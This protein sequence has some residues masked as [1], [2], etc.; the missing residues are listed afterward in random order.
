[1][2][3]GSDNYGWE[4]KGSIGASG[5]LLCIWNSM[6]FVKQ[7]VLLGDGFLCISGEWGPKRLKCNFVN[8]YASN[9]KQKKVKLWEELRQ[10]IM[11]EEGRWMIVGDFN[12]VR[13]INERKG[14]TGESQDMREFDEFVV[15]TGLVDI[16]LANRRYTWYRPDGSAMS[17]LDRVLM[18]GEMYSLGNGW[19]QQGL[20]RTVSDHCP[21]V[22][23]SSVADWGP[24]PFR[25]LDAWQQHPQFKKV[26]E[27]KWKELAE[28]GYAG[29]RCKQKLK[30]LKEFLKGWNKEVFGNMEAQFQ[31]LANGVEQVDLK[32]ELIELEEGEVVLRKEGFQQLWE[33]LWKR[34][35][36]WKQKSRSNW[37]RLG[38][39]N[40]RYFH[41]IANGRKAQNSISGLWSNGQWVEDPDM[42][43]DEMVKYFSKMFR[44][45]SWNRPKPSNLAFRRISSEQKEWL[46]RPFTAEEIEEGLKSCDGS[47]APGPDGYNFNLLKF[48]WSSVRDD[49]VAFFREFHQNCRLVKGLNSSFL[50]LVPK[51]LSPRDLKDFRPISLIGCMYKLLAKVLANRLK[52]VMPEII[53]ETQSA[54][55][56]GRQLVDS[57][58][59]LNE[60]VDEVRKKKQA[61]FVFK[62]DFQK[63]YDCVNWSFLDWMLDA[64]GFG[65][66]WR[67]WIRECLS[68]ARVSVLVNG[69][70]TK[71]FEMGKGL[72]QGDPLS[73]FL[74]L[75]VG[76]ALHGLV[77]K[78]EED[79]LLQGI[80]V[81]RRGL[82]VSLLQFADDTVILG[83]ANKEN[84][85]MVKAILR[86][87]ELMSGLRIN[88]SKSSVYGFNVTDSWV[89]GVAGVL[90]CG[91]GKA[92]FI[93][94]GMPIGG[95]P[96]C[97]KFW[98]PVVNK[99]REKLAVWKSAM[100][101]FGGRLTLLNSVLS[102]LPTFFMS[103]FYMPN[104]VLAQLV[105]I[106]RDFLWGGSREKRKI[107]WVKWE[108][109]CWSKEKGGLGV[110][111]L[112]RRNWAL[113]G[114]W[115]YRFGDGRE[116]LWK[117]VVK[118][119]FYGGKPEVGITDVENLRVSQ[120]WGDIIRIGGNSEKL[121]NM[122]RQGFRW[123]VG[124]GCRVN[125]WR[126]IWVGNKSL[127]DLFP[128]LFQL[129][130][131]KEGTVKENGTW[132]GEGWIWGIE[133]RR[134]RLGREKDEEEGLW[135]MLANVKLRKEV[136]DSWQWRF[137]VEG[138]YVVKSAYEFLASEE[139]LLEGH[140]C[141]FLWC[142]WV[143][144]KVG[145]FGWRLC[146]DRLPTRWN[147]RKRG[148]VL[149]G[150]GLVCG[151]CKEGVEDVNHLF[152]TC[153]AAW[154]VWA[155]VV[156]WWGLEIVMPATVRGVVDFFL[157]CLGSLAG[158]EMGAC[159]FLVTSWYLWYWRNV[160]VFRSNEDLGDRLL[161][162]IQVKSYFWIR[163]KVS[164][165]VFSLI[166]WQSNPTACAMEL[167]SYK[168]SLKEF[169]KNQQRHP[170]T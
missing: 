97:T 19:I 32:N 154:L 131:N 145:F 54:F 10:M 41:K 114:K 39:Q 162:L 81:G 123:K 101:S 86:W 73:P 167:K 44:E 124:E 67:G 38:D 33:I 53:S 110:P 137:D 126:D 56:G 108:V 74:F 102:A 133:W 119:K 168:R 29:Y 45:D 28:E 82:V 169:H 134:A 94:L 43:K 52:E 99:F 120:I 129:A 160:L 113:L 16:K 115:W 142:K 47:K 8:V 78:A 146:L 157:W 100:L 57:V 71:E 88:F 112:R 77:K 49:F 66:K 85:L 125:F 63:A 35:A 5:G 116:G 75:M 22:I 161:E 155:K 92:P 132:E 7:G 72:R 25:V 59:V 27:E 118:E 93:Y 1:M 139:C 42:V 31:S 111:D 140:L 51:K 64:L 84:V 89:R 144:S 96:R 58:L 46:E 117:R 62:A 55:V 3:W 141:K 21:I 50:A 23:K 70:P 163:N 149:Q 121:K 143:P 148:V 69:S 158:K 135:A 34:E 104:S 156:K 24:K 11:E 40:T 9:D 95:N 36:I 83:K 14:K 170:P 30:R 164:G 12:A 106:Q 79:G 48:M 107:S 98:V 152:C 130:L 138:S 20:K 61:A 4:M 128:R 159:I 166:Q 76:E 103:L 105:S 91:V 127:R 65:E 17:R 151:L 6:E 26:V 15:S 150:D 165:S 87:F 68:T 2:L 153:K 122:L 147:L 18:S 109:I 90:H 80:T 136:V 37:V 13:N 60:V